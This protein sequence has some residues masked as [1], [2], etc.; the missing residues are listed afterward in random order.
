MTTNRN[1]KGCSKLLLVRNLL[2]NPVFF[3]S[4]SISTGN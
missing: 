1:E 3:I 2:L 4:P